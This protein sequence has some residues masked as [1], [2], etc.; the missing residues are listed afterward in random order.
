ME[1]AKSPGQFVLTVYV[2]WAWGCLVVRVG[3]GFL[4]LA[5]EIG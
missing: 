4:E 1:T 5:V 3:N 2:A